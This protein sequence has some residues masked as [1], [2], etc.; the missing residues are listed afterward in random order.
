MFSKKYIG[1]P[2][3]TINGITGKIPS[4]CQPPPPHMVVYC[5]RLRRWCRRHTKYQRTLAQFLGSLKSHCLLISAMTFCA[6][7][8]RSFCIRMGFCHYFVNSMRRFW[9]YISESFIDRW[10][11]TL[12]LDLL[13]ASFC[14]M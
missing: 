3:F 4:L 11:M 14:I 5:F 9:S 12:F 8:L 13:L 7:G 2:S 1:L 10:N 6:Q